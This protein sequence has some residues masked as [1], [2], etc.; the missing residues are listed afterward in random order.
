MVCL[1]LFLFNFISGPT[2]EFSS[3]E[4]EV[5]IAFKTEKP[6][7]S[8]LFYGAEDLYSDTVKET[9]AKREHRLILRDLTPGLRYSF[10]IK[11]NNIKSP[12]YHFSVPSADNFKIILIPSLWEKD[13]SPALRFLLKKLLSLSP[14]LLVPFGRLPERFQPPHTSY[15]FAVARLSPSQESF[16]Y[17]FPPSGTPG[18]KNDAFSLL[19]LPSYFKESKGERD[20]NFPLFLSSSEQTVRGF[21]IV[22]LGGGNNF[23]RTY[24]IIE[25]PYS[26]NRPGLVFC[27]DKDYYKKPGGVIYFTIPD[28]EARPSPYDKRNCYLAF[29]SAKSGFVEILKSRKKLKVKSFL[30]D[31]EVPDYLPGDSFVLDQEAKEE[32]LTFS[33]LLVKKVLGYSAEISYETSLPATSIIKWGIEPNKYIFQFPPLDIEQKFSKRHTI[34]LPGLLPNTKYYFRVG[35]RRGAKIY[36]SEEHTFLTLSPGQDE[37]VLSVNFSHPVYKNDFNLFSVSP[38]TYANFIGAWGREM[39]FTINQKETS[40]IR[41]TAHWVENSEIAEWSFPI[42]PGRYYYEIGSFSHPEGK[43][44]K[45]RITIG[46]KV[47]EKGDGDTVFFGECQILDGQINLRLG[48]GD[49][50]ISGKSGISY[51]ILSARQR[52]RNKTVYVLSATP[53][54]FKNKTVL[55]YHLNNARRVIAE[56]YDIS[57][58]RLLTLKNRFEGRGYQECVWDGKDLD[59]RTLPR[60]VYF[61]SISTEDDPGWKV[62]VSFL[63]E[64]P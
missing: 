48:Y 20:L 3:E 44:T 34:Y 55:R 56:V 50:L 17:H 7:R 42:P 62:K 51:L 8:Q 45:T 41:A 11:A 18:Q 26:A 53:N 33:N 28:E 52:E 15:L 9:E 36:W 13:T 4:G 35:G 29:A 40:F 39:E 63:G 61:I 12:V 25:N 14:H 30:F 24:P 6:V 43:E 59:G 1:F 19:F 10:I 46:T 22:F 2:L 21:D 23:Q 31:N 54:P 37:I 38:F 27:G 57:G 60:G 5:I 47:L 64:S 32:E 16:A 58:K 49:T